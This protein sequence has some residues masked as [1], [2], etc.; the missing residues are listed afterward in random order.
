MLINDPNGNPVEVLGDGRL[1]T[2]ASTQPEIAYYSLKGGTA[3][4]W[5]ASLD[6]GADKNVIWLRN[7][8]LVQS[9][10]ID[11]IQVSC[12]AAATVE[13]FTGT[14]NTAGGTVVTPVVLNTAFSKP[15]PSTCR[16]TNTN[17]DTGTGMSILSTHQL[18][19]ATKE[20]I[21]YNSALH[22]ALNGEIAVNVVGD[23]ALTSVNIL[24]YFH[25]IV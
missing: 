14:G 24:G 13:V 20:E 18:G 3:Y 4:M 23:I 12:S 5:T 9:L 16:H 21:S 11:I 19:A 1:R 15:A 6:L 7:D 8:S 17:V 2:Y 10:V 22:L 25:P